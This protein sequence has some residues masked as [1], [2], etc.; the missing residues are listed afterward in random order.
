MLGMLE[1]KAIRCRRRSLVFVDS[2]SAFE[3]FS[4]RAASMPGR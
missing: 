4:R 2:M 3:M 1:A